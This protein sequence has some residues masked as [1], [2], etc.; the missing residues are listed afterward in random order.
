MKKHLYKI[1]S[2]G[3]AM[4][5]LLSPSLTFASVCASQN[6]TANDNLDFNPTSREYIGFQ[7]TPSSACSLG[8]I[9]I[10][11]LYQASTP[12]G[13]LNVVVYSDG[14]GEPNLASTIATGT[15]VTPAATGYGGSDTSTF[16]GEALS[17]SQPY[18]VVLSNTSPADAG[19]SVYRFGVESAD[20]GITTWES[21][22]GGS[23]GTWGDT[24]ESPG[25]EVDSYV[26]PPPAST[27]S[28]LSTSTPDQSEENLFNGFILF[29]V[30]FFGT[31]WLLRKH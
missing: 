12:A 11:N 9:I 13:S 25:F 5:L 21:N 27:T 28:E 30:A 2:L 22:A 17:A 19:S 4:F 24:H 6:V 7:F 16:T 20:V 18:W 3:T 1:I 10:D 15:P 23:T 26:A 29:F 14:G 8:N 31:A